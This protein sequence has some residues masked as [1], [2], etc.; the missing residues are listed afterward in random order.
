M[1][2]KGLTATGTTLSITALGAL[3]LVIRTFYLL[4]VRIEFFLHD[5]VIIPRRCRPRGA[6]VAGICRN[7]AT[8]ILNACV[9]RFSVN[10]LAPI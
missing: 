6:D 4:T 7:L 2:N 10:K 3:V 5:L 9:K 8:P 1:S